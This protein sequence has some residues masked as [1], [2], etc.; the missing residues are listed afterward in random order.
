MLPAS[1]VRALEPRSIA[2]FGASD[3]LNT[4]GGIAWRNLSAHRGGAQIWP[5]NPKYAWIGETPCLKSSAEIPQT[6]DL[7]ILALPPQ[8]A[9][10]ALDGMRTRPPAFVLTAPAEVDFEFDHRT[11][12]KMLGMCRSMG[13]RWIGPESFG[14]FL[15]QR[16]LC[17]GFSP[18]F[19]VFWGK[20]GGVPGKKAIIFITKLQF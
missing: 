15:P 14:L 12:R 19:S 5:V 18:D 4:S 2:V 1:V 6:L 20:S 10:A 13:T 7:A 9:L 11:H 3:R 16:G 8:R 17:A